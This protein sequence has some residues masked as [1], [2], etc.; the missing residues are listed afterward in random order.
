MDTAAPAATTAYV[1]EP[2]AAAACVATSEGIAQ[3]AAAPA[4]T[5][6]MA[7]TTRNSMYLY[8]Q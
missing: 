2:G 7:M 4:A 1:G 6:A 8:L 5:S 3:D